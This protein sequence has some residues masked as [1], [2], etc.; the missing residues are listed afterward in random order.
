MN[1]ISLALI[2]IYFIEIIILF[3]SFFAAYSFVSYVKYDFVDFNFFEKAQSQGVSFDEV[4]KLK[5]SRLVS[6]IHFKVDRNETI[7][8]FDV[9]KREFKYL[10]VY[11]NYLSIREGQIKI[12]YLKDELV[13]AQD[14]FNLKSGLNVYKLPSKIRVDKVNIYSI[15]EATYVVGVSGLSID[16]SFNQHFFPIVVSFLIVSVLLM[17]RLKQFRYYLIS[18]IE[19]ILEYGKAIRNFLKLNISGVFLVITLNIASFGF[20]VSNFT[21]SIDEELEMMGPRDIGWVGYG[22]FGTYFL[23]KLFVVNE[24]FT[25]FFT[26]F[27]AAFLLGFASLLFMLNFEETSNSKTKGPLLIGVFCGL[28]MSMPLVMGEYMSFGVYNMAL[29]LG[30]IFVATSIYFSKKFFLEKNLY[31]LFFA[32]ASLSCAT[33]IYQSFIGV[34]IACTIFGI[35]IVIFE[36]ARSYVFRDI[37][38][39]IFFNCFI[40]IFSLVVYLL[41]NKYFQSTITPAYGY[42]GNIVGW[43]KGL[44][45]LEVLGVTF[46]KI[47]SILLGRFDRSGVVVLATTFAFGVYTVARALRLDSIRGAFMLVFFALCF[48]LSPFVIML[49]LGAPLPGRAL[50]ALPL[51]LGGSWY[52]MLKYPVGKCGKYI[53]IFASLYLIV[54][55]LQFLNAMF[56]GDYLRYQQDSFLGRQ[57]MMTLEA[58]EID[59]KKKPLVFIGSRK[60][61]A[62][63]LISTVNSGGKSFFEDESQMYRMTYFL[64]SLGYSVIT[65]TYEEMA[66]GKKF[67]GEM[68]NWPSSRSVKILDN[69]LVVKLS[70]IRS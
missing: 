43:N 24:R 41:L 45:P 65:P 16:T 69:L 38:A 36:R 21:L 2:K 61:D 55:Q 11:V 40:L 19:P 32:I 56:Y 34:Y 3:I 9:E 70:E 25:P 52:L 30:Y 28:F 58:K 37:V 64:G 17:L 1:T 47:T 39:E 13:V 59:Y 35:L 68:L 42:I 4:L 10:T 23:N 6:P 67:S 15:S 50:Q 44:A 48:V 62:S 66:E 46:E 31:K 49:G 7:F 14:T 20:M 18:L 57:I 12:S 63:P 53:S 29:G 51:F 26:D 8:S 54:I 22:R 60:L 27:S 33:S 5:K